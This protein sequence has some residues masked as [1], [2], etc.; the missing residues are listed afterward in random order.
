MTDLV[1][2]GLQFV[3]IW[4]SSELDTFRQDISRYSPILLSPRFSNLSFV[5]AASCAGI[6]ELVL[7][8]IKHL[9]RY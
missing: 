1:G 3:L 5:Q 6:L 2:D 8:Q 7:P 9:Q 4:S